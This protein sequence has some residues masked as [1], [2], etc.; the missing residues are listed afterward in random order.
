MYRIVNINVKCLNLIVLNFG[1]FFFPYV[2]L[3]QFQFCLFVFQTRSTPE[4]EIVWQM[5]QTGRK[6]VFS[7]GNTVHVLCS[8]ACRK[9]S[10]VSNYL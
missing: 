3:V 5:L 1:D 8:L 6:S 2:Q 10:Q 9:L 7:N 4:E